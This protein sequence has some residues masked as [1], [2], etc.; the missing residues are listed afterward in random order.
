MRTSNGQS[1]KNQ[2]SSS[3]ARI[4]TS[5]IAAF[6][7]I[8][9]PALPVANALMATADSPSAYT[10]LSSFS[11]HP[12]ANII[13][14]G[15]NYGASENITITASENNSL[16]ASETTI[17]NAN[18][19]YSDGL[20][21]PA[22][23]AQG[24]VSIVATGKTSGLTSSN[25]YY[26]APFS[27]TLTT[28]AGD[29]TPYSSLTVS[30]SGYA[31]SETVNLNFAGATTQVATDATGSF[32]DA[33]VVTPKAT[34][35][36]YQLIGVGQASGAEAIA[37][38]YIDG[39]FPSASPNSYYVLPQTTLAFNG[40]GFAPNE[41]VTVTDATT[42][43]KYS[44]FVT[45]AKGNYV[46]QGGFTVP[47]SDAGQTLKF[48][49]TG[50]TS[51]ASTT[52]STSVGQYF[53]NVTPSTYF[54]MPGGSLTLG[55]TGFA[56]NET[57]DV[58]SG[59]TLVSKTQASATG[60]VKATAAIT[61]P[62]TA[63]G[64]NATYSLKGELSGGSGSISIQVGN[65]NPQ[66]SPSSYYIAPGSNLTFTGSG[67]APGEVVAVFNGTTQVSSFTTAT[68]GSFTASGAIS[69]AYNQ[70]GTSSTY[71]LVGAVS[72]SPISFT[73]GVSQLMTQ[74]S[75]SSYYVLPYQNFT[76]SATGFAPGET[77]TLTTGAT[78]LATAVANTKGTA[79]FTTVN[80]PPSKLGSASL[81]ATGATSA[82]TATASVG[83]GA[84]Y[85]SA[86]LSNYYVKPGDTI[87]IT[88][89]GFAPNEAVTLTSGTVT[90]LLQ[91]DAMGNVSTSLVVPFAAN[92]ATNTLAVTLTG[93]KSLAT[94]ST[95]LTLAPFTP[96]ISPSTY[97][98]T[99]GTPV[100]FS[101]T[102]FLAG[103]T[104]NVSLNGAVL[105]S[106]VAT[107]K[108]VITTPAYTLPFGTAAAYTFVGV[109]S[110]ATQTLSIGL[111]QFYAGLQLSS[112]YGTGGSMITA[113]GSGF[114]PNE[115]VRIQS[116]TSTLAKG[117]ADAK[118]NFSLPVQVPYVAAGT[119]MITA[120]GSLSGAA[121]ST[122]YT[123]AQMYNSVGLGS[124]AVPAGQAV[125]IT[126]TGFVPGETVTVTSDRTTGSY[127]F[128]ADS[129]GD[130]NN[131]GFVLPANLAAGNL[132]LTVTG[133]ESFTT[134]MITM[135]VQ[136][137]S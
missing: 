130:L 113:S 121:P 79:T 15:G 71:K 119:I 58:Y 36:S 123:V 131:S 34:A 48:V 7:V 57:V 74:L 3:K 135:Y 133:Q 87:T 10:T 51:A 59:T 75:P 95:N 90:Q 46:N 41:T 1:S 122:S 107:A 54:V 61:V 112:Y 5:S 134:H 67:Y 55:G 49:L 40:G 32:T 65:F 42:G 11:G 83:I 81:V 50:T 102:G 2:K 35:G 124:Y 44:S 136:S 31:P 109:T 86:S 92:S 78:T 45:D 104:V 89:N 39:F 106:V 118:G 111:A 91:S 76:A 84:Y 96:Q 85:P 117:A 68:D 100:T 12:D 4:I 82:A 72:N 19:Q 69:I 26:V 6:A 98:A 73:V 25:G 13:V 52:T 21:L 70:A 99:P 38:Q 16:I 93:A 28:S 88:G 60:V 101:G 97:Y 56:P 137:K 53:P 94:V 47:A 43:Q 23:L 63:A 132:T 120:T 105:G 114:A 29:S 17:S 33:T 127:S 125:T 103:E 27:P 108:G 30:G 66:A 115:L 8:A 77:V 18:G 80:L 110:G 62:T 129:E 24:N 9:A 128:T 14:S 64:T 116:G 126:G 37:Y 22:M 20:Q